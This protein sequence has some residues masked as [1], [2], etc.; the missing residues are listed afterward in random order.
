MEV[1]HHLDAL[2][3]KYNETKQLLQKKRDDLERLKNLDVPI[4][5]AR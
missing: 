3:R 5:P 2:K 1:V 4:R